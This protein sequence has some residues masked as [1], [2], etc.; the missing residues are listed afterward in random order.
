MSSPTFFHCEEVHYFTLARDGKTKHHSFERNRVGIYASKPDEFHS[1]E[2]EV[3]RDRPESPNDMSAYGLIYYIMAE[4]PTGLEQFVWL[5][6]EEALALVAEMSKPR[7]RIRI[8]PQ[9]PDE[10]ILKSPV[11]TPNCCF[12]GYT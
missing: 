3:M 6:K 4:A 1:W 7:L 2:L 12:K 5:T 9:Q 10:E 11:E 8:P